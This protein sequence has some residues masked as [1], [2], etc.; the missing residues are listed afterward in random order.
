[1]PYKRKKSD[2]KTVYNES[3]YDFSFIAGQEQA[4]RA[5]EIAAAGNHNVLLSGPPG[6]GK[7]L[8][9]RSITTIL[10]EMDEEEMLEVTKIY[11]VGGIFSGSQTLMSERPFRSPHHTAS[12]VALIGG[13]QWPKPGEVSLSHRGVLFLDEFPE[14]PRSVLEALRQPLEDGVVTISRAQGSLTFP[15]EFLLVAAQN[16]CPCGFLSDPE[17]HC[18]C[19]PHQIMKYQK[20]VSGP[21]L[22]RIDIHIEVPRL[23]YEKIASE[24]QSESSKMVKLRVQKARDTQQKRFTNLR[25]KTNSEIGSK[26]IKEFCLLDTDAE[27]LIGQAVNQ[28]KLSGRVFHRLLKVARTIADLEQSEKIKEGHIAEALQYRPKEKIY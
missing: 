3:E 2:S 18:T 13:G 15:A 16:P 1:L 26:Y 24:K 28:M 12:S 17:K 25:L 8:L 5:L 27:K 22:D 21:L 7:T 4:K 14:F 19:S 20:K 23:K 10:P 11:S 9:A 6:S